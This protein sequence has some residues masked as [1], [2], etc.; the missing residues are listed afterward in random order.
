MIAAGKKFVNLSVGRLSVIRQKAL[1]LCA[2]LCLVGTG[3]AALAADN[4]AITSIN[5]NQQGANVIVRVNFKRPLT[6]AP[7]GACQIFCVNG[8]MK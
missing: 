1:M 8:V 5:A 7:T 4:Y 6:A 3:T 2:L